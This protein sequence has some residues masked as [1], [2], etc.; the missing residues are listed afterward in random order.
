MAVAPYDPNIVFVG[1]APVLTRPHIFRT[2]N[3][4][5]GWT[6]VTGTAPNRYIMDIAVSPAS[7]Q[8]VYVAF[9]GFDTTRVLKSTDRGNSWTDV[10][11]ILPNVPTTAIAIDPINPSFVYVGN[12]IGVFVSTDAGTS[13]MSWNEGLPEAVIVADLSVSPANRMMR[14]ATH[15]NGVW[16]RPLNEVV[17]AVPGEEGGQPAT[18][19][20]HQNYPNP[21]N[22]TTNVE[23][24]M[25][26]AGFVSLQVFDVL[27]RRVATLVEEDLLPGSHSATFDAGGLA[28]GLYICRLEVGTLSESRKMLLLK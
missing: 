9:G 27:G 14:L 7:S 17:S 10:S 21:F 18:L 24:R 16:Q 8:V 19:E 4:G 11:G 6:D 28:S 15:S 1:T 26:N 22:A 20:L 2:T 25:M 13:W 3:G 12:D 23:F 5:T